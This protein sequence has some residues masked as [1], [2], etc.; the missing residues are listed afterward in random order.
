VVEDEED[1]DVGDEDDNH[2]RGST[3]IFIG[4]YF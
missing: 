1:E 4:L 3:T 2:L